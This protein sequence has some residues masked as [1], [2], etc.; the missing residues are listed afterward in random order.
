[1]RTVIYQQYYSGV[2]VSAGLASVTVARD[3]RLVGVVA[4]Q[5]GVGGAGTG[6]YGYDLSLNQPGLVVHSTNAPNRESILYSASLQFPN[7]GTAQHNSGFIPLDVPL[8]AGDVVTINGSSS[9][10]APASQTIRNLLIVR[11]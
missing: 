4:Q 1:M 8:R 10:T 9:G 6:V 5:N 7:A 11:E 3:G 2:T